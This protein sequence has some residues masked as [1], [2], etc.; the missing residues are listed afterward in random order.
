VSLT[1]VNYDAKTVNTLQRLA[2]DANI[3]VYA[4]DYGEEDVKVELAQYRLQNSLPLTLQQLSD[5]MKALE[6]FRESF[7]EYYNPEDE[8][9]G[10]PFVARLEYWKWCTRR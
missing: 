4:T 6:V 10:R 9:T 2:R 7:R 5:M 3:K 8:E 1:W